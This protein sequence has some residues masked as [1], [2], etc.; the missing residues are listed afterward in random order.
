MQSR[1][2]DLT[3]SGILFIMV[4]VFLAFAKCGPV[5]LASQPKILPSPNQDMYARPAEYERAQNY[6]DDN[7]HRCHEQHNV[8]SGKST[9]STS[10]SIK[11]ISSS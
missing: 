4:I 6:D 9:K 5:A 10:G 2:R 7:I 1:E 3:K 11:S 8:N